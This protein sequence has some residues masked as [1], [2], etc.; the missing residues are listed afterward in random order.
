MHLFLPKCFST[1]RVFAVIQVLE[2]ISFS[3]L[4]WFISSHSCKLLISYYCLAHCLS[5]HKSFNLKQ[6]SGMG[7]TAKTT[8]PIYYICFSWHDHFKQIMH[9]LSLFSFLLSYLSKHMKTRLL[10]NVS[11]GMDCWMTQ[12]PN[13]AAM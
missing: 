10:L 4:W 7:N 5:I 1:F 9:F 12:A 11:N 2:I 13:F 6:R 3:Y 8:G